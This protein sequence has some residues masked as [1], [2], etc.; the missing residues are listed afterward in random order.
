M[1]LIDYKDIDSISWYN[2]ER[3]P[4]FNI[5]W[6]MTDCCNYNCSYCFDKKKQKEALDS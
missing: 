5:S 4:T 2:F 1:D 3:T 6:H